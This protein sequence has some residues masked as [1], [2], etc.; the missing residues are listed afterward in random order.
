[1][2]ATG[3]L[4]LSLVRNSQFVTTLRATACKNLT[5]IGSLHTFTESVN[6]FTTADV[7]LECTFHN[8]LLFHFLKDD[9][10]ERTGFHSACRSPHPLVCERTAKVRVHHQT[11]ALK[12]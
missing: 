8:F 2:A 1:M 11:K 6:G 10:G 5:A 4:Q 9:P 3:L 7:G 12:S